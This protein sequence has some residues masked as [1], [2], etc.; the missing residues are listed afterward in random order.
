M[1]PSTHSS[2]FKQSTYFYEAS[3]KVIFISFFPLFLIFYIYS[4]EIAPVVSSDS[5]LYNLDLTVH[6]IRFL[7]ALFRFQFHKDV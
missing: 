5:V 7:P 4:F 2:S 6:V 1:N 3:L